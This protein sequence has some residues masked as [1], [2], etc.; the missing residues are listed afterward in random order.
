MSTPEP[1]TPEGRLERIGELYR[2]IQAADESAGRC[3]R[4]A[5]HGDRAQTEAR[6]TEARGWALRAYLLHDVLRRDLDGADPRP[7]APSAGSG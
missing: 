3:L 1:E 6:A 4:L 7:V 2:E 5:L